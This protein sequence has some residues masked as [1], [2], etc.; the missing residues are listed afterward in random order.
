MN[1]NK[2]SG[3]EDTR[4]GFRENVGYLIENVTRIAGENGGFGV[5]EF[6]GVF[7]LAQCWKSV[8]AD[9][10]RDCLEKA[11]EMVRWCL[12]NREG[13]GL[14]AGCYLRYST[15]KFFND[16]S[17]KMKGSFGKSVFSDL[18]SIPL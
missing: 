2:T 13:R 17:Q 1:C 10:C 11:G 5:M 4:L 15:H 3:N 18:D 8:S 7:G 9:G 12:P 16:E 14:N 6:K